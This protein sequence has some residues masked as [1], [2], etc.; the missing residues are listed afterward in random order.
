MD[1]D[2]SQEARIDEDKNLQSSSIIVNPFITN[3]M[4][5]RFDLHHSGDSVAFIHE[6]PLHDAFTDFRAGK[7]MYIVHAEQR[8][9]LKLKHHLLTKLILALSKLIGVPIGIPWLPLHRH[10]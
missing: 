3:V 1:S 8:V 7:I 4:S 9:T 10:G 5:H 6:Y 2:S